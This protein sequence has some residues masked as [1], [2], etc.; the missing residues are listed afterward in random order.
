MSPAS[1]WRALDPRLLA[2]ACGAF[3][4]TC[5]GTLVI[6]LLPQIAASVGTTQPV[7]GSAVTVFALVYAVGGPVLLR[8]RR[9]VGGR[10]ILVGSMLC[11][12]LANLATAAAPSL[13]ALLLARGLAAGCAAAFMPTAAAA[14]AAMA[15]PDASARA[16]S[17]VVA[18]ASGA[19]VLGVPVGTWAGDALGWRTVFVVLA[20]VGGLT[21][22]AIR[23]LPGAS[24]GAGT[25][26]RD[27][28]V[29]RRGAGLLL[30]TTLLWAVG[31]FACF[32]YIAAVLHRAAGVG[33]TGLAVLLLV[34][35][36][37]G[38]LGTAAGG[39]VSDTVG[40][41]IAARTALGLVTVALAG[42]GLICLRHSPDGLTLA[43]TT[44]AV[45]VYATGTWMMTPA[46]Q[47][48]LLR[49]G[50]DQRLMLSLNASA[51]YGGVAIGSAIGAQ[52]LT[53]GLGVAVLCWVAAAVT[54]TAVVVTAFEGRRPA[55][56]LSGRLG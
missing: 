42:F 47:L 17:V 38:V 1:T 24:L 36:V 2:L 50:G 39:W 35:G 54:M 41:L 56:P 30:G 21:A 51:L 25:R 22:L 8:T 52:I 28:T 45:V 34:F 7:A 26:G 4:V 40:P 6:G 11:F 23:L 27:I 29:D 15:P 48:R 20:V 32:T 46:Q 44:A 3:V 19:A 43:V 10:A 53:G 31:S 16:L 12:A 49:Y 33:P 9:T 13:G 18:G 5:D 14:A 37:A 55:P